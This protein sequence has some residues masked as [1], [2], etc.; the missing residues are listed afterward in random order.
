MLFKQNKY[1]IDPNLYLDAD[2]VARQAQATFPKVRFGVGPTAL[3]ANFDGDENLIA[4]HLSKLPMAAGVMVEMEFGVSKVQTKAADIG[5]FVPAPMPVHE[6]SPPPEAIHYNEGDIVFVPSLGIEAKIKA[7]LPHGIVN[8]ELADGI[9][10]TVLAKNIELVQ[11][12]AASPS[13]PPEAPSNA[14]APPE[15]LKAPDDASD[16][17]LPDEPLGSGGEP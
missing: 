12:D 16:A 5:R 3:N 6:N 8:I 10:E 15:P 17:G 9:T 2:S 11:K 1:Y 4:A 14:A 13:T 7:V